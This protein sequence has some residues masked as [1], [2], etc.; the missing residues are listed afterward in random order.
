MEN[1]T[2]SDYF[3]YFSHSVRL[4][5]KKAKPTER[6]TANV[7]I[8]KVV[9]YTDFCSFMDRSQPFYVF[10]NIMLVTRG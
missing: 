8:S 5:V 2:G 6:E 7:L 1:L 4:M 3:H 10:A 9:N